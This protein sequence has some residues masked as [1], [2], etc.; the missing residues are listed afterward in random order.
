MADSLKNLLTVPVQNTETI[1]NNEIVNNENNPV[2][3][4]K[5]E[6][7]PVEEKKEPVIETKVE[8][9][10]E[11]PEYFKK[12]EELTG[13]KHKFT[14]D[15][16]IKTFFD[17]HEKV[18]GEFASLKAKEEWVK[19]VEKYV[20]EHKDELNPVLQF[21]KQLG[22]GSLKTAIAAVNLAK[23]KDGD[24]NIALELVSSLDKVDGLEFLAKYAQF[25][26]QTA[27]KNPE[28]ALRSA[29][30]SAGIQINKDDD[31]KDV[32]ANLDDDDKIS[33]ESKVKERKNSIK[34]VIDNT[35]IP[36]YIDPIR[37]L[38]I[39]FEQ[40]K[41]KEAELKVKWDG[42]M[43]SLQS[44]FDK[45]TFPDVDFEF[46]IPKEE[47]DILA[48]E[49]K[50]AVYSGLEPNEANKQMILT[51]AKAAIWAKNWPTVMQAYKTKIETSKEKE[52]EAKHKN[53]KPLDLERTVIQEADNSS[54]RSALMKNL[55]IKT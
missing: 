9:K 45:I 55:K 28:A 35:Q 47:F 21:E 22:E 38:N 48:D 18:S 11:T 40:K 16:E 13:G 4:E 49:V 34:S 15:E 33:I 5:I 54:A 30:K 50:K 32:L 23:D 27:R 53:L 41:S 52:L 43:T 46:E 10:V 2:V 29:L 6:N 44:S 26:S 42:T 25:E 36:E 51:K 37:K 8:P 20:G 3:E 24:K 12:I 14:K 19:E 1:E 17:N 31:L 39:D 7:N